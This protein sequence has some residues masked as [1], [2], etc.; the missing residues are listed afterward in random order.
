M[1]QQGLVEL[2]SICY[3][4]FEGSCFKTSFKRHVQLGSA[5]C[6]LTNKCILRRRCCTNNCLAARCKVPKN[7]REAMSL[8]RI[9]M[10]KKKPKG[11]KLC[12]MCQYWLSR[13]FARQGFWRENDPRVCSLACRLLPLLRPAG[14]LASDEYSWWG[15]LSNKPITH[16]SRSQGRLWSYGEREGSTQLYVLKQEANHNHLE[17]SSD[18]LW[19][20]QTCDGLH[21]HTQLREFRSFVKRHSHILSLGQLF[22]WAARITPVQCLAKISGLYHISFNHQRWAKSPSQTQKC[23]EI[24]LSEEMARKCENS[25]LFMSIFARYTGTSTFS[26]PVF[27]NFP[28][29]DFSQTSRNRLVSAPKEPIFVE[30]LKSSDSP[31]FSYSSWRLALVGIIPKLIIILPPCSSTKKEA[32]KTGCVVIN[33]L[34][35]L[36]VLPSLSEK[37]GRN[38]SS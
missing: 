14:S 13:T 31:N 33:L 4:N 9:N 16:R 28:L 10:A 1:H 21:S 6:S 34:I 20:A 23:L 17:Q 11:K 27:N 22:L 12:S 37:R 15:S 19:P 36:S 35:G 29:E 26:S 38:W 8:L 3:T 32:K 7:H 30:N 25:I 2:R 5:L 18:K 24:Q